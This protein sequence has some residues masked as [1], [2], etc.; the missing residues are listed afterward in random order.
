M[1]TPAAV[2]P[3]VGIQE[4]WSRDLLSRM[5]WKRFEELA[6]AYARELGY[7]VK[8]EDGAAPGG[9]V[10]LYKGGQA[11]PAMLMRCRTWDSSTVGLDAVR[12]LHEAMAARQ[13]GYGVFYTAGE[14]TR[15]ADEFAH[16]KIIDL[17]NGTEFV[18]R[19]RQLVPAVQQKLL[20]EATEGDYTTPTCP[21]C[22]IKMVPLVE[23]SKPTEGSPAWVCRNRPQCSRTLRVA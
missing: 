7:T 5:E 10:L 1:N 18:A 2:A 21:G 8:T 12:E 14:F 19:L 4:V 3:P 20:E 23:G 17:V 16:G 15:E 13:V 11:K 6:A 22:D 9:P